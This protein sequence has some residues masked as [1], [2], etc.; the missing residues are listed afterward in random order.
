VRQECLFG[1]AG[2]TDPG[3]PEPILMSLNPQYYRLIW[4]GVKT[5]EFRRRYLRDRAT[6]WYVYLTAPVSRLA[7]VIDLGEAIVD[8]P[9]RIADIAERA[10]VGNGASVYEYLAGLQQGFALP[11]RRVREYE[12]FTASELGDMLGSF[13]PPQGY[14]LLARH[15]QWGS[16]CDKLTASGALRKM[17][18]DH[19]AL[20]R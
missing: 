17:T 7:A 5:H 11:I 10:R 20:T 3:E 13:H 18:I 19:T 6:T 15:P 9:R 14:T 8:T 4:Q 2:L 16:V 12:G 1:D